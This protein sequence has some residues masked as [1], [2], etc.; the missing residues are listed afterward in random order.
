[1]LPIL[2]GNYQG[3]PPRNYSFLVGVTKFGFGSI[4]DS[5]S[6][7]SLFAIALFAIA[8]FAIA[9]FAIALFP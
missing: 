5:L 1:M 6:P 8:L 7:K 3:L 2:T 4:P 9:L